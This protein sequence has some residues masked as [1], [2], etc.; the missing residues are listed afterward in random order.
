[1]TGAADAAVTSLAAKCDKLQA[2]V[3]ELL[4]GQQMLFALVRRLIRDVPVDGL[5]EKIRSAIS[6]DPTVQLSMTQ[7]LVSAID[8]PASGVGTQPQPS[9]SLKMALQKTISDDVTQQLARAVTLRGVK[10]KSG[11]VSPDKV[12]QDRE[13]GL[14]VRFSS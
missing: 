13:R 6:C 4:T 14:E 7:W 12:T 10:R 11:S 2:V 1:M 8:M 3:T 5:E 9:S